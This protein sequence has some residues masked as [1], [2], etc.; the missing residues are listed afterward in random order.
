MARAHPHRRWTP[1]PHASDPT[2]IAAARRDGGPDPRGFERLRQEAAHTIAHDDIVDAVQD[3]NNLNTPEHQA[4]NTRIEV[5]ERLPWFQQ[6]LTQSRWLGGLV[7]DRYRNHFSLLEYAYGR[8]AR[9]D[10]H[11]PRYFISRSLDGYVVPLPDARHIPEVDPR[12]EPLQRGRPN[13]LV[14]G[15]NVEDDGVLSWAGTL[16]AYAHP[17]R[18]RMYERAVGVGPDIDVL[19]L[20]ERSDHVIDEMARITTGNVTERKTDMLN[21]IAH[22]LQVMRE[23]AVQHPGPPPRAP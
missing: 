6:K 8:N 13:D 23:S 10:R 17:Y 2:D 15:A 18:A 19:G 14:I 5:I 1:H 9:D 21:G 4:V 12:R 3:L 16:T 20:G 7:T 22:T 11:A